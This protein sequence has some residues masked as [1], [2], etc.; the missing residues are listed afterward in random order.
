MVCLHNDS[1]NIGLGQ[2]TIYFAVLIVTLWF[3][4]III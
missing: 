1:K 3:S 2:F 4:M